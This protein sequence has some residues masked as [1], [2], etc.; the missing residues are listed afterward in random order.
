MN[1]ASDWKGWSQDDLLGLHFLGQIS[2]GTQYANGT[3]A[4]PNPIRIWA[5]IT[6]YTLLEP[7]A[8]A[9]PMNDMTHGTTSRSFRAWN[10]SEADEMRGEITACTSDRALGIQVWVAVPSRS[11]PMNDS[12]SRLSLAM[13]KWLWA[14]PSNVQRLEALAGQKPGPD[15][16]ET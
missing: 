10:V 7:G 4:K 11:V 3:V 16:G 6:R 15:L 5:T 12:C 9:E 1:S 2:E 8:M 13:G 14:R